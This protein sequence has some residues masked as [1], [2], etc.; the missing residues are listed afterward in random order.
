MLP[1]LVTPIDLRLRRTLQRLEL[2][3]NFLATKAQS[4]KVS[5]R[6]CD[7]WCLSALVVQKKFHATAQSE[8]QD[9]NFVTF[10][11]VA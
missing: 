9:V 7:T 5:R 1:A 11:F 10:A 8:Q 2:L 4:R 6:L 3:F